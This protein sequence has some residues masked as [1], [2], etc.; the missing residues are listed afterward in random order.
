MARTVDP[1]REEL[2]LEILRHA[3]RVFAAKGYRDTTTEDIADKVGLKKSSLYH[4]FKTKEDI[5]F[6]AL[7]LHLRSSLDG[8]EPLVKGTHPPAERLRLGIEL[9]CQE[10]MKAPYIA[11]LFVSDRSYL[12]PSHLRQ[13]MELRKKHELV[14][15]TIIE[16]G[17]TD[18]SFPSVD[19]VLAVKLI[20]G[21]LNGL[22]WWWREDGRYSLKETADLYAQMLVDRML[23]AGPAS[24]AIGGNGGRNTALKRSGASSPS[25][26]GAKTIQAKAL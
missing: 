4:Y 18:G 8:L 10:M 26:A 9:Q 21:A 24:R 11:N 3:A 2:K 17:M 19:S 15:R 25:K 7:M 23:M 12:K 1:N 20:Y 16:Q 6:R 14:L 13:C 22:P 5:L